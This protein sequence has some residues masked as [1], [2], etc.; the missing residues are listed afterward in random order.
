MPN[1]AAGAR[2]LPTGT[3]WC[4]CAAATRIGSF[5]AAGHDKVAEA[6]VILTQY[7]G[8]PEFL[9]AHGFGP[10]GRNPRQELTRWR[11]SARAPR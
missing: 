7:G 10:D 3:C 5:F 1:K 2:L 9:V 11:S 4:G 8:V 6:A